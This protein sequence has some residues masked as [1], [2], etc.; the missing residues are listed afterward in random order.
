RGWSE[1]QARRI[2]RDLLTTSPTTGLSNES[3][4]APLQS[5]SVQIGGGN[6]WPVAAA[7]SVAGLAPCG[8][9]R[10]ALPRRTARGA[11]RPPACGA[12]VGL[13]GGARGE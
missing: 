8:G 12:P 5:F 2:A 3:T 13:G 7:V 9:E 4:L 6:E 10:V 1:R 11:R